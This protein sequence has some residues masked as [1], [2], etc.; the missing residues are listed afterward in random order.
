MVPS[1]CPVACQRVFMAWWLKCAEDEAIVASLGPGGVS[2][3]AAF[4]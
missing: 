4:Y 3:L 1:S 2:Q